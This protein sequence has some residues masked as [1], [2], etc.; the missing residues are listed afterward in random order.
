MMDSRLYPSGKGGLKSKWVSGVL[1]FYNASGDTVF[2]IN[3]STKKVTFVSLDATATVEATDIADGA[4]TAAKLGAKA[5]ETAKINDGAVT[6]TQLGAKAVETAKINDAAVTAT[7]LASN[8]VETAK[9]LDGA[10]TSA[11]LAN[12]AGLAAVVSAGLGASAAYAKTDDGVKT[13]LAGDAAARV[14]L[15]IAVVDETFADAGGNQTTFKVG[16]TDTDDKYWAAASFTNAAAGTIKVMAGTLTA[17]KALIVTATKAVGAGTGGVSV[18]AL[19][20]DQ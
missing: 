6:A 1:T 5:V 17:N 14:A 13:L 4:I 10:V 8:A 9:I 16:E 3:P 18:T 20:L 12:G 15:L 11:K 19:V 7:Q 2:S